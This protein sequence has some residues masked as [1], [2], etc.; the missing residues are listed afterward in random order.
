MQKL[1]LKLCIKSYTIKSVILD[2]TFVF[3]FLPGLINN[4]KMIIW[5]IKWKK[6]TK[7]IKIYKSVK[8]FSFI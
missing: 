8:D 2:N 6:Y 7:T 5:F 4:Y 3:E 1:N